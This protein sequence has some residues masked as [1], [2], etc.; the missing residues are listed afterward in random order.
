M[1]I[2]YIYDMDKEDNHQDEFLEEAI[3]MK[4]ESIIDDI[5]AGKLDFN[6]AVEI[7]SNLGFDLKN[8]L[9]LYSSGF[10]E[11]H[12]NREKRKTGKKLLEV[13]GENVRIEQEKDERLSFMIGS[14]SLLKVYAF[15]Q[16]YELT[17]KYSLTELTEAFNAFIAKKNVP[18]NNLLELIQELVRRNKYVK[19]CLQFLI[20][21]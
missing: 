6:K 7:I 19:D 5:I 17:E 16:A 3:S 2:C 14:F 18:D 8:Q 9:L 21:D 15:A 1:G 10:C 13:F 11:N 12:Q 4:I 20:F